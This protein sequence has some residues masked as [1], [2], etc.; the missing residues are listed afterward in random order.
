[1]LRFLVRAIG[2]L[3]L[4]GGF[5]ALIVDGTRSLA[6]NSLY[7][8]SIDAAL[9][10]MAPAAYQSSEKWVLAHL[11]H[12]VWDPLLVHLFRLPLSGALLA[13]GG[14]CVLLTHKALEEFG[15]PAE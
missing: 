13:F 2:L 15:Y 6:G 5:I 3:V 12:F 7:V 14:L 9:Q 10:T 1:M 4:A 11:P 8:T